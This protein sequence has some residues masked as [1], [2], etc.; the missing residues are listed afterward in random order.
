MPQ[1]KLL[2][3]RA[4]T[5]QTFEEK[6]AGLLKEYCRDMSK[7]QGQIHSLEQERDELKKRVGELEGAIHEIR[8]WCNNG[9]SLA[10]NI[11][12]ITQEVLSKG[13]K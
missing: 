6:E 11:M 9:G 1:K 2:W 12:R 7:A 8:S 5:V 10:D 4:R 13:D 3:S